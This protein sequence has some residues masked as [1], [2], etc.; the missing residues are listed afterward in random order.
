MNDVVKSTLTLGLI[1]AVCTA[2][3]ATTWQVTRER[4]VANQEAMLEQSLGPAL[5]GI[6]FDGKVS[7]YTDRKEPVLFTATVNPD[8]GLWDTADLWRNLQHGAY[9]DFRWNF[10]SAL[11]DPGDWSAIV[12]HG[13]MGNSGP[14][15][16]EAS[17]VMGADD[18][19][20]FRTVILPLVR[21]GKRPFAVVM[22]DV[23]I[24]LNRK[25]L[26]EI[27]IADPAAFAAIIEQARPH[28]QQP[29]AAA[30]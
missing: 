9:A 26:S 1:A 24:P 17:Q 13:I 18:R 10:Q 3:V 8:G 20:V 6:E 19:T 14:E 2:L 28:V 29:Q 25:M 15:L 7:A 30:A 12:S 27:A 23:W 4:I 11:P 5:K 21:L 22:P 16:I